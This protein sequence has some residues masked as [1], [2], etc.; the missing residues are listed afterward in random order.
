[1]SLLKNLVKFNSVKTSLNSAYLSTSVKETFKFDDLQL[2]VRKTKPDLPDDPSK[3]VFGGRFT[4][5]MLT[6][7]WDSKDG[8]GRPKIGPL[9]N[10]EIHPAAKC[11]HYAIEIFEGMKAYKGVD[12]KVRLFRPDLN[13]SRL[14]RSATRSALPGFDKQELFKCIQKLVALEK[15]WIP[16]STSA[17]L[18]IRP[19]FIGTEP[20]LGVS[21]SNKALLY[22]LTSPAGP[23]FPSGFKPVT[24]Y[25]NPKYIRAFPGGVGN[26]KCG[27]NYGPTVYVNI[28][29]NKKGCQQVLWLF[30]KEEYLTEA[31]TMNIFLVIKNDQGE[32]EL[33]TPPLNGTILEGVTRQSIL[34]LARREGKIKVSE[35]EISMKETLSLLENGR[36]LEAFGSGTACVVCPIE[37]FLY[38]DKKFAIPTMSKGAPYMTEF[39][40]NLN[41]IQYGLVKHEW[42]PIVE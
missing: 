31:G 41:Q 30:D 4:D 32:V 25:A 12:D 15:D 42:A 33:I 37:G 35:R 19:T 27:S 23:Y 28:E 6:I 5:H 29:A 2:D 3:L 21:A 8:W 38:N 11:L 10:L 16:K 40:K 18:Y 13:L 1:M 22:V 9:K 39:A 26:Y 14:H 20:T 34:D 17:S 7:E 24:L 36:L